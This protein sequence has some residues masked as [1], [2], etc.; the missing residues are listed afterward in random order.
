MIME[1]EGADPYEVADLPSVLRERSTLSIPAYATRVERVGT[2]FSLT[3]DP[4]LLGKRRSLGSSGSC[5]HH[6][7]L[8]K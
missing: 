7:A 1:N 5:I 2:D 3:L 8:A 6:P 4:P